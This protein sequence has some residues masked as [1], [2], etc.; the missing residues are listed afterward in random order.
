MSYKPTRSI[1]ASKD[2]FK[3]FLGFAL[4]DTDISRDRR[5]LSYLLATVRHECAGEWRP[6]EEFGKGAGKPYG[7][8]HW[9]TDVD[10]VP[11]QVAYYGRGYVQ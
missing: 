5:H 2:G 3:Q 1:Q 9:V 4:S 10:G 11:R 6:I 7:S 8:P